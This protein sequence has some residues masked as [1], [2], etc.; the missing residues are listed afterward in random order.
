MVKVVVVVVV[1]VV[2]EDKVE[3][4]RSLSSSPAY[5]SL[6]NTEDSGWHS[7]A[8]RSPSKSL[9]SS[10]ANSVFSSIRSKKIKL[11][12]GSQIK[13]PLYHYHRT[14]QGATKS[15]L[16]VMPKLRSAY[17]K[18]QGNR[19]SFYY[20]NI[21]LEQKARTKKSSSSHRNRVGEAEEEE[22]EE[23]EEEEEEEEEERDGRAFISLMQTGERRE[24]WRTKYRLDVINSSEV[25]RVD[26]PLIDTELL[27]GET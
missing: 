17:R 13:H 24:N 23:D 25:G 10:I 18:F 11:K 6:V 27:T 1:V 7:H 26:S 14:A 19:S 20:Q 5:A 22:E 12:R 16:L 9:S 8:S 2:E 4:C 3:I 21:V 15:F